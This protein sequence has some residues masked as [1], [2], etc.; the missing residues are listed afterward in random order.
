[1]RAG[2]AAQ[3]MA[4]PAATALAWILAPLAFKSERSLVRVLGTSAV[5]LLGIGGVV[6]LVLNYVPDKK[7]TARE[8]A[9]GRANRLCTSLGRAARG[10]PAAEGDGVHLRRPRAAADYRDPS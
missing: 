3:M 8:S 4:L 7:P 1:M 10:R 6:P 2:P 5:V 9:I